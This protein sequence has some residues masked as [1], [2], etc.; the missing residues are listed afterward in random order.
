MAELNGTALISDGNLKAYYRFEGNSNATTAG[1]NGTDTATVTYN[2]SYGKYGQGVLIDGS[3]GKIALSTYN[4]KPMSFVAWV[5]P[6]TDQTNYILGTAVD[7]N[8]NW[9]L[10]VTTGVQD[11]SK[12][13]IA[14]IGASNT[15]VPLNQWSHV[16]VTYDLSGNFV[17]Y[18]N[19]T[20]DGS[21]TGNQTI[22]SQ[23]LNIGKY[24]TITSFAGRIDDLAIFD[25]VLTGAEV[26]TLAAVAS[27]PAN[28][29]TWDGLAKASIKS[30]N[31]LAISSIKS[32]NNLQ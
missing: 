25:R 11:L 2:A 15:Q 27:G 31:S 19:G 8:Y 26:A 23:V 20:S 32:V 4:Y 5:Y 24:T 3:T 12:G 13:G 10:N 14:A 7:G 16:A 28:L 18:L 22:T 1:V 9:R 6:T 17:F 21:G 30:I 29:K